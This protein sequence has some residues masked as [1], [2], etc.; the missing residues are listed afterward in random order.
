MGKDDLE[1]WKALKRELELKRASGGPFDAHDLM[2]CDNLIEFC[3]SQIV[4]IV[5]KKIKGDEDAESGDW[6][7]GGR[8]GSGGSTRR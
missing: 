6:T 1:F 4:G 7:V 5:R 8:L 3:T 2:M